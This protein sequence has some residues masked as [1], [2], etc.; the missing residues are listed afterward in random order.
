MKKFTLLI[1]MMLLTITGAKA[2]VEYVVYQPDAPIAISWD[3]SQYTGVTFDTSSDTYKSDVHF[4]TL[5]ENDV[6]K[7]HITNLGSSVNSDINFK[8][9]SKWKWASIPDVT[10]DYDNGVIYFTIK[11]GTVTIDETEIS[12]TAAEMIDWIKNRGLVVN[13]IYFNL[14][15]ITVSS[16]VVDEDGTYTTTLK[17]SHDCADWS[18]TDLIASGFNGI[19]GDY[20]TATVTLNSEQSSGKAYFQI[21]GG[22]KND[23]WVT[24][25]KGTVEISSSTD[26]PKNAT[27]S[28]TDDELASIMTY[29]LALNGQYVTVSDVIY[30]GNTTLAGY[31]P[32][33]IP[34]SGYA[35]FYG[36]STCDLPD[37][38]TNAYYVSE[39]SETSATL[40]SISNIP[41][42]QGVI[43][44]GTTG[45]YQLYTTTDEAASVSDN[46]LVG[47]T[48]RTQ[49]TDAT[50]KYVLY[51]NSGSPEFRSITENTYLDAYKCYLSTSG[52]GYARALRVVF[53]DD[54][55]TDINSVEDKRPA[56][57][58]SDIIYNLSGQV[59][60]NPSR[61]IYIKNGKKF[62][63]E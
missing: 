60:K 1:F 53:G 38:I 54:D 40:T 51:N 37:G 33:Y 32:V 26:S 15:D 39:T 20:I 43:L 61:G 13:G 46:K 47:S 30:H 52:S 16:S 57:I 27:I 14:L 10:K 35:T 8:V 4:V 49:I 55:I 12:Y 3:T 18:S 34:A 6:I 5:S 25:T 59:V 56:T 36:M 17:D 29:G 21:K 50:S 48:T 45:I 44:K 23:G 42:S 11:A 24:L 41:A 9:G 7:I 22:G 63:V 28:I 58:D 19:T 31:R 2:N 62:I